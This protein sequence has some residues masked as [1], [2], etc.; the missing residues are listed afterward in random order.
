MDDSGRIRGKVAIITGAADGIG[1]ATAQVF[2]REGASLVIADINEEALEKVRHE[3]DEKG[4]IVATKKTNVAIEQEVKELIEFTI[5]TYS[6][7]DI[8][9][10]NAGVSGGL[11][12]LE[13]QAADEWH[14]TYNV[15]VMGPVYATKHVARYMKERR[16]G[17]IVNVASVAGVRSG[18]GGLAYSAS[19]AAL[20][21]FTQTSAC[22]LGGY[23]VRVNAICPGF[24]ETGMTRPFFDYARSAGKEGKLG[25]WCE[26]KRAAQPEEMAWVILFLA[27]DESSYL[28]GQAIP[29]DG[30]IS[31]SLSLPGKKI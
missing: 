9:I 8:L 26:L 25:K 13:D 23:S 3:I 2:S 24:T 17:S 5:K 20:I 27:C 6:K 28:T 22:E 19:K 29:V 16:T 11:S 18:A 21:N 12:D 15:N 30:G 31:A 4:G 7:I 10:N 14:M 1:K